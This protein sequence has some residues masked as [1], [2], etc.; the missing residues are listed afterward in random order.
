MDDNQ[1]KYKIQAVLDTFGISG[2]KAA[3]IMNI[4]Y[5]SYRKKI[6]GLQN[7]HFT[8]SDLTKLIEF[9][10]KEAGKL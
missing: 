2:A 10:K 1:V 7:F 6:S 4:P 8:E 9:I 3:A 5:G